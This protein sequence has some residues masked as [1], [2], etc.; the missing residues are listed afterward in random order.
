MAKS[1]R[2]KWKRK[3]RAEKRERYGKKEL[4]KL[5]TMLRAAGEDDGSSLPE[6]EFVT[7][8]ALKEKAAKKQ[9]TIIDSEDENMEAMELDPNSKESKKGRYPIWMS[10]HRIKKMKKEVWKNKMKKIKKQKRKSKN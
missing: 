10:N 8:D 5:K 9:V 4:E 3:M 1:L 7:V 6:V 2:S